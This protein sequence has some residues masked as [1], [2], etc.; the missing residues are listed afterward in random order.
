MPAGEHGNILDI[1]GRS[2][3][4]RFDYSVTPETS[5]VERSENGVYH[6]SADSGVTYDSP[7]PNALAACFELWLDEKK[8]DRVFCPEH[9]ELY[10]HGSKGDERQIRD[11]DVKHVSEHRRVSGSDV[12]TLDD[13]DPFV[14]AD[15]P[16]HLAVAD[17]DRAHRGCP[18]LE[19]AIGETACG[20]THINCPET[21]HIDVE[22]RE[23]GV[24][25]PARSGDK[26]FRRTDDVQ[27]FIR[28][29]HGCW[30]RGRIR[31]YA[32][33]AGVN[34]AFGLGTTFDELAPD[35]FSVEPATGQEEDSVA[36]SPGPDV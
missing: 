34:R 24:E 29:H 6:L 28:G 3:D 10:A 18:A 21:G 27:R 32:Y 4:G 17:I 5:R 31:A 22:R 33:E 2:G 36:A 11:D 16:M 19:Q 35:Q 25:F 14:L 15:T 7:F 9:R 20:C 13:I 1:A 30:L 23:R 26:G 12:R 8:P